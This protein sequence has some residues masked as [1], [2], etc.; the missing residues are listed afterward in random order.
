MGRRYFIHTMGCQMNVADSARMSEALRDLA[1]EAAATPEQADVIILNTCAVREKAIEKMLSALG[2]YRAV[3]MARGAVI[4]VTGCVAQQE[5]HRLLERAPYIDFILGPDKIALLKDVVKTAQGRSEPVVETAW[6]ATESYV[7]PQASPTCGAVTA[8]VTVM[9]GCDNVC[10]F[11]IVPQTRGREISRPRDEGLAEVRAHAEV[12][13][14]EVT[15]LGQNVNSFRG[16]CTFAEL[17]SDVAAVP[18]IARVRFTTSHPHDLSDALIATMGSED[19]VMPHFHLP[20][21]SGSDTV[22]ARMRRDYSIASYRQRLAAL[23][24]ARSG[25][26]ITTDIIVGFPGET[27]ADFEATMHLCR[28]VGFDG[29]YAF[30]YSRRPRTVAALK[31]VTWGIVDDETKRHR[32]D[33][34]NRL[35]REVSTRAMQ[36]FVGK[37]LQVLVEGE[38]KQNKARQSGR[39]PQNRVVNFEGEGRPGEL[40]AVRVERASHAALTGRQVVP[41]A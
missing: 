38:S 6:L 25:I 39:T 26:A 29:I 30:A 14:R 4:G 9:K 27:E 35:Q 28:D 41:A 16:G 19:R 18:G 11:C 12:G 23:R 24:A 21:Q 2:R 8:F 20:V 3:K 36:E 33:C 34:I 10:A 5:K 15:L 40:V 7:F 37:Q 31:E 13:V 22:L 1:F 32:L 17:L